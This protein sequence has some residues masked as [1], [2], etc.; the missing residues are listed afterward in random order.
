M[1]LLFVFGLSLA[2]PLFG[3]ADDAPPIR[4]ADVRDA[5]LVPTMKEGVFV[6]LKVYAIRPGGRFA[7]PQAPF[8]NGDLIEAIDGVAVVTDEGTRALHDKV[9]L[10]KADAIVTVQRRGAAIGLASKALP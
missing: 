6:G 4:S 7:Q 3:R 1:K 8:E 10:G 5:R 2:T 9:I